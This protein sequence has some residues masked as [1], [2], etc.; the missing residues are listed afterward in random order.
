MTAPRPQ[1]SAPR[2]A[3]GVA[4]PGAEKGARAGTTT[5]GDNGG[6]KGVEEGGG[7]RCV[8]PAS[9]LGAPKSLEKASRV[10]G[11]PR[12]RRPSQGHVGRSGRCRGAPHVGR[13]AG[14]WPPGGA[15]G[16][17]DRPCWRPPRLSPLTTWRPR[18]E[19][20]PIPRPLVAGRRL[21]PT[22]PSATSPSSPR[23]PRAPAVREKRAVAALGSSARA[24]HSHP[25]FSSDTLMR[26]P[27]S[28]QNYPRPA[29]E[30]LPGL[31]AA[32]TLRSLD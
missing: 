29:S 21:W 1:N 2:S 9:R 10:A 18:G 24:P 25:W 31:G 28:T 11:G 3:G 12:R 8:G 17:G 15:E 19:G 13:A 32:A 16:R 26:A 5:M 30:C 20:L 7:S 23:P 4:T 14:D 6:R 22:H 27:P